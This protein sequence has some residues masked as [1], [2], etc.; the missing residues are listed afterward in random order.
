MKIKSDCPC[1]S[2]NARYTQFREWRSLPT[3][4]TEGRFADVDVHECIECDRL[5]LKYQVEYGSFSRSARWARGVIDPE[6]ARLIRSEDATAF[7]ERL[8]SYLRGGSHYDGKVRQIS[9]PMS[10]DI[11]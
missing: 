10:W 7:L 6:T 3:D 8:P 5:W 1:M 9:G 11:I 2:G 4:K